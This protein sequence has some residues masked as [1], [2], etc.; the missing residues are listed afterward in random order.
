VTA[1]WI[2]VGL[3]LAAGLVG[4]VVPFLPG[5]P[6]ILA[7]ALVYAFATDWDPVG[8]GRLM[9]LAG[10]TALSYVLNYLAGAYGA[11]RYGGS[12]WAVAGALLGALLGIGLGP[13]GLLVGPIAGAVAGELLRTGHLER[14][15]RSGVGAV[16]GVALGI[17]S[18]FALAVV[19]VGLFLWWIWR[20]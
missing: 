20:A 3:L 2:I 13:V 4:S 7:G 18:T 5:T 1:V 10:L 9:I 16:V 14:S 11:R 17:A 19:M 8:L 12:S 6:L 15:M